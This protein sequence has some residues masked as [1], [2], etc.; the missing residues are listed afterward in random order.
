MTLQEKKGLWPNDRFRAKRI[1]PVAKFAAHQ[2]LVADCTAMPSLSVRADE[3]DRVV[4]D[5]SLLEVVA[6]PRIGAFVG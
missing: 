2:G 5:S 6:D 3:R 4:G 1:M